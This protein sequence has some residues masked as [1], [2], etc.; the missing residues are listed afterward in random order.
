MLLKPASLTPQRTRHDTTR[1]FDDTCRI[2]LSLYGAVS[3][4]LWS[5][6]EFTLNK[7]QH[8]DKTFY[9]CLAKV[10]K[11]M[12]HNKPNKK[13]RSEQGVRIT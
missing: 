11:V 12:S 9:Q 7:T 4:K 6:M 10:R 1:H 5:V 13:N 3:T 8:D 2:Q